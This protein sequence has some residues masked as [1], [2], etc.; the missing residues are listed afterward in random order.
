MRATGQNA[1]GYLSASGHGGQPFRKRI[2]SDRNRITAA[3]VWAGI[4]LGSF[5]PAL[6]VGDAAAREIQLQMEYDPE[7]PFQSGSPDTADGEIVATV[8]ER[9]R[10][11][12]N[13]RRE[14]TRRL[15]RFWS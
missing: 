4:D 8:E 7:P 9:T 6:L 1:R 3:G 12:Y 14:Q 5:L 13:R 10:E 15:G 2:V 11:L